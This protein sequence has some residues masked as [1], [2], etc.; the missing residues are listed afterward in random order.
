M[1]DGLVR[2]ILLSPVLIYMLRCL[3]G[4]FIGYV[5]YSRFIHFELFWALLSIILVI[6]PEENDSKRLSVERFKS[7]FV[8]SFVALL[9][10]IVNGNSLYMIVIGIIL[11][12]LICRLF[13]IMNM[14]RVAIVALLVIMIQPHSEALS[15]TPILRFLSV[16]AGCLI[17]LTIV[18][19]SSYAI[20]FV[21][22]RY[23]SSV[24]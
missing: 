23:D 22:R 24:R 16:S 10:I 18:I 21:R 8:G 17:G 19:A 20:R 5:L 6:S 1:I 15:Y 7:N 2:R 4:F 11:T 9:C 12:I 3:A 13:H 14:A